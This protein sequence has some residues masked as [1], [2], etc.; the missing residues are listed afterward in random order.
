MPGSKKRLLLTVTL[1][2][3]LCGALFYSLSFGVADLYAYSPRQQLEHW[4][5]TGH[6]PTADELTLPLNNINNAIRWQPA[7]AEFKDIRGLLNYYQALNG[8]QLGQQD[9]FNHFTQ[10]ALSDYREATGLRPD[11]PYSWA[12]LALMKSA[13]HQFD[14]EYIQALHQATQLGPWE[15]A[16][17]LTVTEAG[18]TG[19]SNL[20]SQTRKLVI[21]NIERGINRNNKAIKQRL[22]D[23][24]KLGLIC[25]YLKSSEQRQRLCGF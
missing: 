20:D 22:S 5:K 21:N 1:T 19:W 4:Q 16:V 2:I 8:Y 24:N 23:I 6:T 14:A 15:N 18:M 13:L 17:N 11:W 25:I 3:A 7:N 9:L 12:N 10:L